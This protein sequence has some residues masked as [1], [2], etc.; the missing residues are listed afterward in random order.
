[1][2]PLVLIALPLLGL[3]EGAAAQAPSDAPPRDCTYASCALRL[4]GRTIYAGQEGR[5]AGSFGF[6]AAPQL[7][8][9]VELSDSASHYFAI[10]EENH[11]SGRIMSFAG[12]GMFTVAWVLLSA[13]DHRT[14]QTSDWITLGV[15]VAGTAA[16]IVGH[17]RTHRAEDALT[18]SIW[19]YNAALA[20]PPS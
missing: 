5:E 10:V 1:M 19:W 7:R 9:L 16:F 12:Q 4:S 8:P 15:G 14:L 13:W 11:R 3:A 2:R 18:K 17:R 6:F 20:D